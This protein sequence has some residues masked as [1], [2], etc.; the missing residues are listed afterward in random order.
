MSSRDKLIEDMARVFCDTDWG[1]GH[2][3]TL[4]IDGCERVGYIKAAEAALTALETNYAVVP[5]E[6]T[7]SM[8]AKTVDDVFDG[9]IEDQSI[10]TEI[11][12]AMIEAAQKEGME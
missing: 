11:Y 6:P 1:A 8:I 3:D 9:A 10:I 2:F 7:L 5:K 4:A 12:K